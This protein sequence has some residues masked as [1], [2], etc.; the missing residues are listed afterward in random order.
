MM[1]TQV[2]DAKVVVKHVG[3]TASKVGKHGQIPIQEKVFQ[4]ERGF[5]DIRNFHLDSSGTFFFNFRKLC[6]RP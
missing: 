3:K 2:A 1:M 6:G 5:V 4:N